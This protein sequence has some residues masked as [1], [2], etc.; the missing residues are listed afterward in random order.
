MSAM[1]VNIAALAGLGLGVNPPRLEAYLGVVLA[2][3]YLGSPSGPAP[4]FAKASLW[5]YQVGVN[6]PDGYRV[7]DGLKPVMERWD[8]T[9][10]VYPI[11]PDT[12]VLVGSVDG[13]LQLMARELPHTVGC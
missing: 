6:F 10:N 11:K 12:M 8:D 9:Y 5:A 2:A 4:A 1:P 7:V 3:I 13:V